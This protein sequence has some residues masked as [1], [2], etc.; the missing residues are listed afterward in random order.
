MYEERIAQL[1]AGLD[2]HQDKL[3]NF[4]QLADFL[5]KDLGLIGEVHS[6]INGDE[7]TYSLHLI[8]QVSSSVRLTK[9]IKE[10]G[11]TTDWEVQDITE[12]N[13]R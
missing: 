13:P 11:T 6:A 9:V 5:Y 12:I 4:L 1:N 3:T 8:D 10:N 2:A 7:I